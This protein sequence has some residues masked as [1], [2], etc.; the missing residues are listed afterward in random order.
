MT[1]LPAIAIGGPPH[2]GK[3]VLTYSLTQ[4]LREQKIEHYVL[5][6]CP[7]GEGDWSNEAAPERVLAIRQKGQFTETFIARSV[8]RCKS[9]ICPYWLTLVVAPVRPMKRSSANALT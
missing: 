6:A 4:L 1:T 5:R 7:D 3:S 8:L 2:S 9:G